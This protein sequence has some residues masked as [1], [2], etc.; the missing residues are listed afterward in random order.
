MKSR[1]GDFA[2][3]TTPDDEEFVRFYR[4]VRFVAAQKDFSRNQATSP[5]EPTAAYV[6]IR[7]VRSSIGV[8]RK[9]RETLR[10]LGL[11]RINHE[12]V[13]LNTPSVRGS[14]DKVRHLVIVIPQ[15]ARR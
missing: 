12:R 10:G 5:A 4:A 15:K 7:Q 2:E 3:R 6:I 11:R 9:Q 13:L 1:L 14:I 8:P